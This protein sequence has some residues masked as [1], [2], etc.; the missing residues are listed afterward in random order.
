MGAPGSG[1]PRPFTGLGVPGVL[2]FDH[3]NPLEVNFCQGINFPFIF[4]LFLLYLLNAG[5]DFGFAPAQLPG[6]VFPASCC[7]PGDRVRGTAIDRSGWAG[8]WVAEIDQKIDLRNKNTSPFPPPPVC[9]LPPHP[10]PPSSP[11]VTSYHA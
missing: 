4:L 6:R 9:S 5:L 3:Q 2:L 10:P 11:L 7:G 8:G 1:P